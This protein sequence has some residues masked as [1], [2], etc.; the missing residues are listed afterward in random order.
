ML[1][2]LS[3]FYCFYYLYYFYYL[4]CFFYIIVTFIVTRALSSPYLFSSS[5]LSPILYLSLHILHKLFHQIDQIINAI[6]LNK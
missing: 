4:Y 5:P 1:S 2:M 6:L 3:C